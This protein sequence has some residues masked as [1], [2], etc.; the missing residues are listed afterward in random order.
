MLK[1]AIRNRKIL[2]ASD[3]TAELRVWLAEE[4]QGSSAKHNNCFLFLLAA[5]FPVFDLL[6]EK[7]LAMMDPL[8]T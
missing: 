5:I 7:K 2:R 3:T 6:S 1:Y 8:T 4:K